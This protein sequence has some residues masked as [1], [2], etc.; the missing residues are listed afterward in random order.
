MI[1]EACFQSLHNNI[2]Y[3]GV[4]LIN[5]ISIPVVV[6]RESKKYSPEVF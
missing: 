2:E 3:R 6:Q 5:F 4:I 1:E